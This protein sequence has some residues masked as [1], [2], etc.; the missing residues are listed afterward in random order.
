M[1]KRISFIPLALLLALS[2]A[3]SGC[4]APVPQV[5]PV[6]A[7][8]EFV[9]VTAQPTVTLDPALHLDET[10]SLHTMNVYSPLL[11]PIP[12]GPP[13]AHLA[14]SWE[15]SPDG[16]TYTFRLREGV[17]FHDGTYLTAE[18]VVF[19]MDRMLSIGRGYAWLWRGILD[20]GDTVAVDDH[21]VAFHLNRPHSP[22][23]AS[24][25]QLFVVNKDLVMANLRPGAFGEFG[26][27]GLEFLTHQAA[28]S[29]PYRVEDFVR[30]VRTVF[31]RFDDYWGGW[32][33]GQVDKATFLIVAE[34]ATQKMMLRE[35]KADMIEQWH[36][37]VSFKE[38]ATEP[39]IVVPTNP[40]PQLFF[41][42]MHNKKPP[43]DN[44]Y[45]RR[46]ISY[47]FDYDTAVNVIFGG[48]PPAVGPVPILLAGHN[49]ETRQYS[50]DLAKAKAYLARW[51]GDPADYTLNYVYVAGIETSMKIG[52]L[53]KD[54]LRELGFEVV[55]QPEPW[56]RMVA[57]VAKPETTPSFFSVWITA[58]IPSPDSH[59]FKMFHPAAW[60]TFMSASWYE[61]PE[62]STL[63]E[64][65]RATVDMD[66]S[67]E[68]YGKAQVLIAED[69]AG[70]FI[71]N[72]L[73]RVA[74]GDHITG[75]TFYG[76]LGFNL[77]WYA[78]KVA[79][80]R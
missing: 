58:R 20:V 65:A 55:M 27:F 70:L 10:E 1:K 45:V 66:E 79:P 61:N 26:D 35:G 72:P 23:V 9:Y 59:T 53:L 31:R 69:A 13:R 80:P 40:Q 74:H 49:P 47:A 50:R 15:A 52:L 34:L 8:V 43:L 37:P 36:T 4:P 5:E 77:T 44:L 42:S 24:M 54:N 39:G 14:E 60:G 29:G 11:W 12:G 51:G 78:L 25:I 18:D 76:F 7:L 64:K 33:P 57:I 22:F 19:S 30:G 56:G 46:A 71:A 2:L 41:V 6:P 21:T 62:V 17:K 48:A 32:E 28:G 63:L 73:H 16:L 68:L 38:L 75:Y 3:V 67:F